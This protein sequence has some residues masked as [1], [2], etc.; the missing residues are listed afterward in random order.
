[1]T[2][3]LTL[4]N[5]SNWDKEDYVVTDKEGNTAVLKPGDTY[6]VYP[7]EGL[8]TISAVPKKKDETPFMMNGKQMWP[9]VSVG[10]EG[11]K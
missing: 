11:T 8:P 7:S 3:S 4:V 1:M 2:M 5:T 10:F 9:V 6:M